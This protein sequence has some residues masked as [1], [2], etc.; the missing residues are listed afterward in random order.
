M[1]EDLAGLLYTTAGSNAQ[2]SLPKKEWRSRTRNLLPDDKHFHSKDLLKL[3]LKP[4]ARM[5]ARKSTSRRTVPTADGEDV[6]EAYWANAAAPQAGLSN[7]D[8]AVQ[9][10]YDAN[11][12]QDDNLPLPG[13]IDPDDDDGLEFA[14]AREHLSPGIADEVD[15][16]GGPEGPGIDGVVAGDANGGDFGANLVAQSRRLRPEYV[17]YARVA[18]KVDVRRLKQEMWRGIGFEEVVSTNLFLFLSEYNIW[19][20]SDYETVKLALRGSSRNQFYGINTCTGI[21]GRLLPQLK[22][23]AYTN[24][25]P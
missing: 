17:Q 10:D 13:G 2:I 12:F 20:C 25:T 3:F 21:R 6:D 19:V 1:T 11:F 14:D 16:A 18:K 15:A 8:D 9:G 5:G 23:T 4:K 7:D 24:T 22:R